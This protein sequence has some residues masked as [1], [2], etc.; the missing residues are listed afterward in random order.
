MDRVQTT[1]ASIDFYAKQISILN[2]G[3]KTAESVSVIELRKESLQGMNVWLN[4][5]TAFCK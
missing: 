4:F 3:R 1:K 2:R 5:W